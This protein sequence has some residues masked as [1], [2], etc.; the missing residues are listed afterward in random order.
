ML[1]QTGVD[2]ETSTGPFSY[3][4]RPDLPI[5]FIF[6]TKAVFTKQTKINFWNFQPDTT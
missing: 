2:A 4:T 3:T 5:G 1:A 6:K